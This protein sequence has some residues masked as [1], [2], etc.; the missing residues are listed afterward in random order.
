MI[1][2]DFNPMKILL[3]QRQMTQMIAGEIPSPVMIEIDPVNYCNFGCPWCTSS[4]LLKKVEH[5][6]RITPK[7]FKHILDF[8]D[9]IHTVEGIYWCGGGEPTLNPHLKITKSGLTTC[10]QACI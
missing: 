8:I 9:K 5:R 6:R 7:R 1:N 3:Y 4:F 10:S 2:V